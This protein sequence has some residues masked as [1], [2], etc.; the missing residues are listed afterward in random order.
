MQ[1]ISQHHHHNLLSQNNHRNSDVN[2]TSPD[3]VLRTERTPPLP[4]TSSTSLLDQN[5][6][7]ISGYSSSSTNLQ[8]AGIG[9]HHHVETEGQHAPNSYN[10]M[11]RSSSN[12]TTP[13]GGRSS[14]ANDLVSTTVTSTDPEFGAN[15]SMSSE[16]L[17]SSHQHHLLHHSSSGGGGPGGMHQRRGSLQLWQFLVALLD[18]PAAR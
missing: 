16:Q 12:T 1:H 7:S 18:E 9:S 5:T 17:H 6:S 2:T 14:G 11:Y 3:L 4:A 15:G 13:S 10:T 8:H